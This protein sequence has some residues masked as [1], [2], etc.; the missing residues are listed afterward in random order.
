MTS[1][2][3]TASYLILRLL[4][5][6]FNRKFLEENIIFI[7]F[8]RIIMQIAFLF[9]AITLISQGGI[10]NII[11]GVLIILSRFIRSLLIWL[12]VLFK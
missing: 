9:I 3:A 5:Y 11:L 1:L 4:E 10:L 7:F 6:Q 2:F 12:N 8:F